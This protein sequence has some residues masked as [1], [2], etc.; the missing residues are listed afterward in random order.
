MVTCYLTCAELN[1][2]SDSEYVSASKHQPVLTVSPT[3]LRPGASV[4]LNCEFE[5]PSAGWRFYWYKALPKLS[6]TFMSYY[7]LYYDG[8]WMHNSYRYELLPG[9]DNGTQQNFY[10]I[11]GQ[12]HTAGYVCR[13]ARLDPVYYTDH[14][15]P[16]FV[17]SGDVHPSASLTVNPDRVQHFS[18]DLVSLSCEGNST[19]WRVRR[20]P[21]EHRW[22]Y[23]N[24]CRRTITGSKCNF[25]A[26]PG[27]AVYW[28]E[29][30][31][32]KFSNAVNITG[33]SKFFSDTYSYW[34]YMK[35]TNNGL[36]HHQSPHIAAEMLDLLHIL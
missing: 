23:L 21:E 24:H 35:Q 2:V 17:W 33:H 34:L 9:K 36:S 11:H 8:Y 29:F 31:S 18:S 5:H 15:E 4:N 30:E 6:N 3:W 14:S 12:T 20:F 7:N 25:R 26:C 32:G 22:A 1:S 27:T 10:I 19:E 16:K 28:C 13:A